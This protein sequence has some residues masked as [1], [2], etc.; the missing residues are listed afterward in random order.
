MQFTLIGPSLYSDERGRSY[1]EKE[2]S[3]EPIVT[4]ETQAEDRYVARHLGKG[5]NNNEKDQ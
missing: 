5:G 4:K 3:Y 2:G 1:F